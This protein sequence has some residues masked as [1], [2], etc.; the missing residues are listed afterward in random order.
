MKDRKDIQELAEAAGGIPIWGALP[1]SPAAEAGI[2]YGD[3]LLSAN[4]RETSTFSDYVEAKRQSE[5]ILEVEVLRGADVLEFSIELAADR[6]R[7]LDEELAGDIA[8]A[9]YFAPSD[10]D[11]D[12]KPS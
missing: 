5:G 1:G 3:I 11:D 2:Q 7:D 12:S 6:W 10:D 9:G 4:G 8:E